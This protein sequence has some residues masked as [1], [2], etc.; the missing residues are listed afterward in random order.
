ME[1][2]IPKVV[3]RKRGIF[4]KIRK[5]KIWREGRKMI[6]KR[7]RD[8]RGAEV[9]VKRERELLMIIK[10]GGRVTKGREINLERNKGTID[11]EVV[12]KV[13]LKID[14]ISIM[15]EIETENREVME[16]RRGVIEKDRGKEN[17]NI[18]REGEKDRG[19]G[20]IEAEMG[21]RTKIV[22][23]GAVVGICEERKT[24]KSSLKTITRRSLKAKERK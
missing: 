13:D 19:K 7:N 23:E 1:L 2:V 17:L 14:I 15:T 16:I 21:E 3:T 20:M 22:S 4:T 12:A 5:G 24:T 11:V 6:V 8:V 18:L 9:I 10:K